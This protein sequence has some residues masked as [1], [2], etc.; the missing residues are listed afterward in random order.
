MPCHW[1]FLL[2]V[3]SQRHDV[4]LLGNRWIPRVT[5][6]TRKSRFKICPPVQAA[7]TDGTYGSTSLP[8][9][10]GP[11]LQPCKS[12]SLFLPRYQ[13]KSCWWENSVFV[14]NTEFAWMNM[15]DH[16]STPEPPNLSLPTD[17]FSHICG[18]Q[19]QTSSVRANP[20]YASAKRPIPQKQKCKP[21]APF[22]NP[23]FRPTSP[24]PPKHALFPKNASF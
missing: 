15:G 16:P 4:V 24:P 9:H 17:P 6:F 20:N 14:K 13:C 2:G 7:A 18:K 12:V 10:S 5:F 3:D 22:G 11:N 23:H 8:S 19:N 21:S 1:C